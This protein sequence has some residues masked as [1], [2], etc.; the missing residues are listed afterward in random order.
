MSILEEIVIALIS[1]IL[2]Y[3][4]VKFAVPRFVK[5]LVKMNEEN[6]WLKKNEAKIRRA[7]Q[8]FFMAGF[9]LYV[10]SRILFNLLGWVE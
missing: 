8:Y 7:F 1:G 9:I 5:E 4:W 10:I 6:Q 3:L 2:T